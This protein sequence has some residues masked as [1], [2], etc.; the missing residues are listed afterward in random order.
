[1][2]GA[3]DSVPQ[4]VW[5]NYFIAAQGYEIKDTILY[6]DNTSAIA[7]ETNGKLSSGKQTKHI[8]ICYF[9][10]QDRVRN[11]EI[12]LKYCPTD[13]MLADYFT[14]PL[15]GIKFIQFRDMI[16]GITPIVFTE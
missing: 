1:M 11:G 13:Q 4:I 2:V 14:K 15:Q 7:M 6:Q 10:I 12:T 8:N 5:T 9:F 3:S 16:L